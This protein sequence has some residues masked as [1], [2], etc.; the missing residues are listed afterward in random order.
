MTAVISMYRMLWVS[1][2]KLRRYRVNL[3]RIANVRQISV[4]RVDRYSTSSGHNATSD[5]SFR[6]HQDH[7]RF[8]LESAIL[9]LQA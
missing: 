3:Q 8:L 5:L 1:R 7:S 9:E 6:I 2:P 4:G